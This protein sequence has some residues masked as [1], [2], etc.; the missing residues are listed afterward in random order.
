MKL[1]ILILCFLAFL[2]GCGFKLVN[3]NYLSNYK[4]IEIVQREIHFIF[5]KNKLEF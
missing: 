4:L 3:Q 1:K 5:I 2:T